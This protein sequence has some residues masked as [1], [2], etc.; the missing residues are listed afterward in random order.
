MSSISSAHQQSGD[1][2]SPWQG[3]SV[4]CPVDRGPARPRGLAFYLLER[5]DA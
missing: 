5:R 2:L 1:L 3:L 4:F